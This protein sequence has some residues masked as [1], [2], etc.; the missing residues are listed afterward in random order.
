VA[1]AANGQLEAALARRADHRCNVR[2][3]GDPR[4]RERPLVDALEEDLSRLV[5]G[6][7]VR[8]D[9]LAIELRSK[10][11]DPDVLFGS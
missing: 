9:Q 6:G 4:D 1:A 7:F 3:A 8:A 11:V 5:V 2:G 10:I